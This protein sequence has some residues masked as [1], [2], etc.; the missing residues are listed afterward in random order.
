MTA[1]DPPRHH[2]ENNRSLKQEI[3]WASINYTVCSEHLKNHSAFWSSTGVALNWRKKKQQF[4]DHL[5]TLITTK[6]SKTAALISCPREPSLSPED[7]N[8]IIKKIFPKDLH[9]FAVE[10][11]FGCL[12]AS[13]GTWPLAGWSCILLFTLSSLSCKTFFWKDRQGLEFRFNHL[14]T[15]ISVWLECKALR[16]LH[17]HR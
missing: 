16:F 15:S 11:L 12:P 7:R 9:I 13:Q 14:D 3:Q 6:H 4:Q 8:E 1:P 2:S 17:T 10:P 5:E